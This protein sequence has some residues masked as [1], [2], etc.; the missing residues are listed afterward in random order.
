GNPSRWGGN[1]NTREWQMTNLVTIKTPG[2]VGAQVHKEAA[3][4]FQGFINELES[5]GY[6]IRQFGGYNYRNKRGGSSLSEHAFGNAIDINW[7]K[8]PMTSTLVTDL[9]DNISRI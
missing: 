4:Y 8:N 7:D 6:R 2:G 3:P 9:P 1:S 5:M